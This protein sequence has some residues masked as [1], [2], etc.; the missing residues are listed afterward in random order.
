MQRLQIGIG[1][2][3]MIVLLVGLV[4]LIDGRADETERTSVPEASATSAPEEEAAPE[5]PLVEAGVV[6]DLP[7]TPETDAPQEQSILP[8]QGVGLPDGAI[9]ASELNDL[10]DDGAGQQ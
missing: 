10:G 3:V 9:G 1:G 2:V 7:A 6:P 4:S 8:E 5:D